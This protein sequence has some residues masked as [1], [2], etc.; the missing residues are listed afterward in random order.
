MSDQPADEERKWRRR[1]AAEANDRAWTL[2]EKAELTADER[3][4]LLYA[5]FAAAHHWSQIGTEDQIAQAELLLGRVHALL[6]HGDLAMRF[7][8][9]AFESITFRDSAP[10]EVA[11]AHAI[12]A[13]AAAASGDS[14]LHATHY[15]KAKALGE[16]LTDPQDKDLFLATF[17]RI[18]VPR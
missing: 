2:T 1:F 4:E 9:A 14:R 6:G 12:L 5:A 8:T 10:W 15:A 18:P 7:A 11:F 3:T 17:T 13:D 16:N